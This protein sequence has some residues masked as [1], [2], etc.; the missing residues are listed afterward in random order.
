[1]TRT[2][3]RPVR[4]ASL[5]A[6]LSLAA[7]QAQASDATVALDCEA[8]VQATYWDLRHEGKAGPFPFAQYAPALGQ[9]AERTARLLSYL[10]DRRGRDV[11]ATEL[12]VEIDRLARD[13][14]A[15][16]ALRKLFAALGN[17]PQLIGECLAKPVLVERLSRQYFAREPVH[18]PVRERAAAALR[19]AGASSPAPA[20]APMVKVAL[21]P[22]G[23]EQRAAADTSKDGVAAIRLLAEFNVDEWRIA[24]KDASTRFSRLLESETELRALRGDYRDGRLE[25]RELRW[26]KVAFDAWWATAKDGFVPDYRARA[27]GGKALVLPALAPGEIAGWDR[28]KDTDSYDI[29]AA[30]ASGVVVSSGAEVLFWG[31]R[32]SEYTDRVENGHE[33]MATGGVAYDPVTDTWRT[34]ATANAPEMKCGAARGVW[35]GSKLLVVRGRCVLSGREGE[36]ESTWPAQSA[37]YDPVADTWQSLPEIHTAWKGSVGFSLAWTGSKAIVFGGFEDEYSLMSSAGATYDPVANAWTHFSLP[38]DHGRSGHTAI[39]TGSTMLVMGGYASGFDC[40]TPGKGFSVDPFTNGVASSLPERPEGKRA[41]FGNVHWTG[42]AVIT[43]SP[44]EHADCNGLQQSGL[45]RFTPATGQWTELTATGNPQLWGP[46]ALVGNNRLVVWGG[47]DQEFV[48][49]PEGRGGIYRLDTNTWTTIATNGAPSA[50]LNHAMVAHGNDALV[51]GGQCNSDY[52]GEPFRLCGN[53]ARLTATTNA[54]HAVSLPPPADGPPAIRQSPAAGGSAT[55]L[56]VWGGARNANPAEAHADGAVYDR[57]T[58]LW[59]PLP[60]IGAPT[61]RLAPFG[62]YANGKFVVWGGAT[63]AYPTNTPL[64]DGA[65]YDPVART[66]TAM[67]AAPINLARA[68]LATTWD[69]TYLIAWG[70]ATGQTLRNDGARYDPQ[71]NAWSMM[72]GVSAPS[73]RRDILA[74][75]DGAGRTLIWRGQ[76]GTP[77]GAIYHSATNAW[78][79]V[80]NSNTFPANIE[81]SGTHSIAWIGDRFAV[82]G[83][84]SA[85]AT[86]YKLDNEGTGQ[87]SAASTDGAPPNAYEGPRNVAWSGTELLVWGHS[88]AYTDHNGWVYRPALD[89]WMR[90]PD[91]DAPWG[92]YNAVMV[93]LGDRVAVWGAR[94]RNSGSLWHADSRTGPLAADLGVAI[95]LSPMVEQDAVQFDIAV[96]NDGPEIATGVELQADF[97]EN[98]FWAGGVQAPDDVSCAMVND[99][100]SRIVCTIDAFAPGES[101]VVTVTSQLMNDEGEGAMQVAVRGGLESDPVPANDTASVIVPTLTVANASLVEGHSGTQSMVFTATLSRAVAWPV[102]FHVSTG[103]RTAA[104]P[105]D[106]AAFDNVPVTIPAGQLAKTFTVTVN[107]DTATEVNETF[108]VRYAYAHGANAPVMSHTGYAVAIGTILNDDGAVLSVDDASIVEGNAGDKTMTFTVR[109]TKPAPGPVTYIFYPLDGTATQVDYDF[110]QVFH[111]G[112]I[113]AGQL[114]KTHTVTIH[115]DTKVEPTEMFTVTVENL[116]GATSIDKSATGTIVNDDGPFLSIGDATVTEGNAGT[117]NATFTV[118]RSGVGPTPTSFDIRTTGAGTATAGVDYVALDLAGQQF[119]PNTLSKTFNVVINGDTAVEGDETFVVALANV[120]GATITDSAGLG[121][122]VSDELPTLSIADL[123]VAE[124]NTGTK[125]ANFTVTLSQPMPYPV[126]FTAATNG[127]GSA[128][129]GTD[130]VALPSTGFTIAAGQTTRTVGVTLNGDTTIEANETFVVAL[131]SPVGATLADGTALGTIGND[132]APTLSIGDVTVTEGNSGTKAATFTVTLSRTSPFAVTFNAATTG[133]GTATAGVDYTAMS[134]NGLA[135]PAGALTKTFNVALVGDTAIENNETFV[136]AIANVANATVADGNALGTIGNDDKPLLAIADVAI[137]EGDSGT[138]SAV[139]TVSISQAAPFVVS[140]DFATTGA[141]TATA[142]VD[143]VAKSLAGLQIPSGQTSRT[144]A[145]TLNGDTAVEPNETFVAAVTNVTG[146]GVADGNALGT[147][148]NDD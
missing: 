34:L 125:L 144:I 130:Y 90:T 46:S 51:F 3:S 12:Q 2:F 128:T 25:L 146:A 16:D 84:F 38:F 55:E 4:A 103:D 9:R 49:Q 106:F 72:S 20:A 68:G 18:A 110:A 127:A 122:I 87:W 42:S 108:E 118:T 32:L 121:R 94:Y 10:R 21:V 23:L 126:T 132:D 40:A 52:M 45:W 79:F 31:G 1:V 92:D 123:S 142:G 133:A 58:D 53:A 113:P 17:D 54:W 66:W 114:T 41:P 5:L 96:S 22:A 62:A 56:Y 105:G 102:T 28:M 75:S 139:F 143:Y 71:A 116:Q 97:P 7:F 60:T 30:I 43:Y 91:A 8:L 82:L 67:P 27:T 119:A 57:I 74:A 147:I 76:G 98:A 88:N 93:R 148:G 50:R 99:G 24:P 136:V 70:G 109:L 78:S 77:G 19:A 14:R 131:G 80:P 13:T 81:G 120:A 140:F 95:A 44:V 36:P 112:T 111:D 48:P 69:G 135:V 104:A 11:D 39:W 129:A 64:G 59:S 138:K 117:K 6:V 47:T 29:D 35:T 85:P 86:L 107:G 83:E 124:G 73:A 134:L 63:Y 100:T 33:A 37:L 26:A 145:V 101:R 15:P 89:R 65:V 137:A 115:G 61:A 141:G